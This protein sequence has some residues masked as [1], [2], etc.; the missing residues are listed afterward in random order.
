MFLL[1]DIQKVKL[2]INPVSAA[3]N[4]APVDGVPAWATS[5]ELIATVAPAEDGLSAY[6]VAT[7]PVGVAQVSVKVDADL[8]EGLREII[9]T[10]DVEVIASEAAA[11]VVTA[12]VPEP[13]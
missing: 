2:T 1:Q 12:G 10:F 7:G 9:G 8:G 6:V 3:G 4:P 5:D 11:L 13:K